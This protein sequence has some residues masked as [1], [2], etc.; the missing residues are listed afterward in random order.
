MTEEKKEKVFP[1]GMIFK[2]PNQGAPEYV[3]GKLSIKVD[4]FKEFLDKYV[5]NGWVNIDLKESREGKFYSELDTWKP[6]QQSQ[7]VNDE[8]EINI[9]DIQM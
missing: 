2:Q 9:D 3:K 6:K 5:E 4:D 7:Q 1:N 8:D